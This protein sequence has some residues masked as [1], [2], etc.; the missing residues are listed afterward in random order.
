LTRVAASVGGAATVTL[1]AVLLSL[2]A[3]AQANGDPASHYLIGESRFLPFNTE[4]DSDA[5]ERLDGVLREADEVGFEIRTALIASPFDLGTAFSLYRKPQRYAEFLG[6][7][8][9]FMYPGRLLIVMP[10]GFGYAVNGEPDAQA[11]SV[12]E[13]MR[14]PGR[15]A[16]REAEA[17]TRAVVRLAAAA[18]HTVVVPE[19]GSETQ[20]RILIAAAVL[21]GLALVAGL[22][23]YHRRAAPT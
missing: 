19:G 23:L 4:I 2:P 20:D 10:N 13:R 1:V 8:L 18:G 7:E 15:N 14:P 22:A 9:S 6:L 5:V 3:T 11:S 12:L 17:A 21:L 16:T